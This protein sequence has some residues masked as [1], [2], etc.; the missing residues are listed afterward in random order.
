MAGRRLVRAPWTGPT[1]F[2]PSSPS[3]SADASML[4]RVNASRREDGQMRIDPSIGRQ[5]RT[6]SI[7][8]SAVE[9]WRQFAHELS[10]TLEALEEDEF[11]TLSVKRSNRH[12]QFAGQ[13]SFGMRAEAVSDFY[14]PDNE[15]LNK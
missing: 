12:V 15:H 4:P 7:Q 10:L 14:L 13:G 11:L 9:A 8:Y 5:V 6:I 1:A 3:S 2:P